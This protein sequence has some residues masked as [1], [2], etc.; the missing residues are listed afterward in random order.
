MPRTWE[1]QGRREAGCV[2]HGTRAPA[3]YGG[4]V[5]MT[6]ARMGCV[7]HSRVVRSRV[8]QGPVRTHP[9]LLHRVARGA[10]PTAAPERLLD[11]ASL[12]AG[13]GLSWEKASVPTMLDR[14][15]MGK[16]GAWRRYRDMGI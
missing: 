6:P 8:A 10:K 5:C 1:K 12:L 16:R 15:V 11:P 13:C 4:R 7:W 9:A 2:R 3:R 14:Q